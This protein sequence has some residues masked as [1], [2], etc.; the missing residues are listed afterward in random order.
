MP[1]GP[2]GGIIKRSVLEVQTWMEVNGV[3]E[4]DAKVLKR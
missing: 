1:R 4:T 3:V 2:I